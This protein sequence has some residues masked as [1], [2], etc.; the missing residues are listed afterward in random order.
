MGPT[1]R[2]NGSKRCS[3]PSGLGTIISRAGPTSRCRKETAKRLER[4]GKFFK[5][6]SA[7]HHLEKYSKSNINHE[8]DTVGPLPFTWP[9]LSKL[10]HL[11]LNC[12][13]H[14]LKLLTLFMS[15][16]F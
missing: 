8:F 4:V 15:V 10:S 3:G 2:P 13:D 11:S 7:T 5:E 12:K 9:P 16:T 6:S 1:Q 14:D